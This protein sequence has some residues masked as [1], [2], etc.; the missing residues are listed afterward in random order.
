ML[1]MDSPYVIVPALNLPA[2]RTMVDLPA[3]RSYAE[4][5]GKSWIDRFLLNGSTTRGDLLSAPKRAAVLDL[6]IDAV[7]S[8]RLLACCWEPGDITTAEERG[9][10]PMAVLR[11]LHTQAAMLEFL[12]NLPAAATIYSHPRFGRPFDPHTA[13]AA[14]EAGCLPAGGKLAAITPSEIVKYRQGTPT[15]EVWDGSSRR[16]R[17]SI[18]AGA[19]GVVATPL[20]ALMAGP[21]P[22]RTDLDALQL[23]IDKVQTELDQLPSRG[24]KRQFLLE[25]ATGATAGVE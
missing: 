25:Q 21:L 14:R 16:I 11:D 15:F 12:A 17:K 3:S 1:G 24:A 7:G 19:H 10:T 9:V 8:D 4:L 22:D 5:A 23:T 2:S 20:A 18:A 6:W 13:T